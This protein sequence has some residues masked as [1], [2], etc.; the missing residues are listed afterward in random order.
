MKTN[1]NTTFSEKKK[2]YCVSEVAQMLGIG[3][4]R[5]YELIRKGLLPS[6]N[7][8]GY[9]VREESIDTFLS[10]YDNYDLSDVDNIKVMISNMNCA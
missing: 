1:L 8:G 6:M 10:K 4:N 9:K 5:V 3:E 7:L 2:L